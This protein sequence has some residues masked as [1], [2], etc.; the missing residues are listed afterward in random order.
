MT[1]SNR[2]LEPERSQLTPTHWQEHLEHL[3]ASLA[4]QIQRIR[5]AND[6]ATIKGSSIEVVLRRLLKQYLPSYFQIGTGQVANAA[7]EVSPQIDILLYD[8]FAFPRLAVNEDSSVIVC[9]ESLV[10]VVEVKSKWDSKALKRHF[11][12]FR[13]VDAKREG[14]FEEYGFAGYSVFVVGSLPGKGKLDAFNDQRR[15]IGLYSLDRGR[16]YWSPHG[17]SSFEVATGNALELFMKHLLWDCMHKGNV[18]IGGFEEAYAAVARYMG[19]QP[20]DKAERI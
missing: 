2:P 8:G 5:K 7:G 11:K 18:E 6:H 14:Y 15:S 16:A 17:S 20:R 1:E 9:Q 13:R 10:A 4:S 3:Q 12:Q 19:W